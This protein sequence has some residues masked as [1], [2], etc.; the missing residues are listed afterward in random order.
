MHPDRLGDAS[1]AERALAERRMREINEAWDTLRDPARRKAYDDERLARA[2]RPAA[3]ASSGRTGA[4]RPAPG[5]RPVP[6]VGDDDDLVDVLPPMTGLQ[7]GLFRHLPWV[8]L[9]VVFGAIFVL[10]AYAGSDDPVEPGPA[11]PLVAGACVDVAPGPTAT[12]V[13]CDGPHE[14]QIVERVVL[15]SDC[16]E[17]TE[18]RRLSDDGRYDCV[19]PS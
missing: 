9:V 10:S 1:P 4:R 3:S 8:V 5:N 16:P 17:G 2:R 12:I 7:A 6:V 13:G 19:V 18:V 14:L 15:A 11:D